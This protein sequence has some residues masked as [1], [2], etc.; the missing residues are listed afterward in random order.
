ML[1]ENWSVPTRIGKQHMT[2]LA[3]YEAIDKCFIERDEMH[4]VEYERRDEVARPIEERI[5]VDSW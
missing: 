1:E 4:I 5:V 3:Y 2:V